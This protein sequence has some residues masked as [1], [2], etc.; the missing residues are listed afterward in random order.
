MAYI[1]AKKKVPKLYVAGYLD[2][3]ASL[4]FSFCLLFTWN[5]VAHARPDRLIGLFLFCVQEHW[6]SSGLLA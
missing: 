3:T 6:K 1:Y 4:E 5:V 2:P